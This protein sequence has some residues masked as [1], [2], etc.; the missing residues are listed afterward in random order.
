MY[1]KSLELQGFKSFAQRTRFDFPKGVTCIVGPNGSGKSN[2]VDAVR[3]VLGESS[4]KELRG[5]ESTDVI[6]NGAGRDGGKLRAALGMAEVSMTLAECREK[7]GG[8]K[9]DEVEVSRRIYRDGKGE[10]RLNG[11]ACRLRD[12]HDLI[13][14]TGI[15]RTAYSIMEQGKMDSL[16]SSKPED[17]RQVFEEAAGITKFKREKRE[18]VKEL[19]K[20]RTNLLRISDVLNDKEARLKELEVQAN[21][22]GEFHALKNDVRD[23]EVFF[24]QHQFNELV[25]KYEQIQLELSKIELTRKRQQESLEVYQKQLLQ[26][27]SGLEV[28]D[29]RRGEK[30]RL[31]Q[32]L[33]D[34]LATVKS[35][36]ALLGERVTGFKLRSDQCRQL[37]Q[38]KRAERK[39]LAERLSVLKAGLQCQIKKMAADREELLTLEGRLASKRKG[40][41]EV[42][43]VLD[44]LREAR[45]HKLSEIAVLEADLVNA[46]ERLSECV[47]KLNKRT[48]V[49]VDQQERW[50]F[51]TDNEVALERSCRE[52]DIKINSANLA[53]DKADSEIKDCVL[54]ERELRTKSRDSQRLLALAHARLDLFKQWQES[55]EDEGG[56]EILKAYPADQRDEA[57]LYG[58][59]LDLI[60]VEAGYGFAIEAALGRH[61]ELLV[62]RDNKVLVEFEQRLQGGSCGSVSMVSL[63]AENEYVSR[64]GHTKVPAGAM[65]WAKEVI[66]ASVGV[67]YLAERIF[68]DV[69]IV[70][71]VAI[72]R[73]LEKDLKGLTLVTLAGDIM[74][75]EGILRLRG[76]EVGQTARREEIIKLEGL[77]QK[78]QAEADQLESKWSDR[79]NI[80]ESRRECLA[81]LHDELHSLKLNLALVE[82]ELEAVEK[83]LEHSRARRED[84]KNE[85]EELESLKSEWIEKITQ[86]EELQLQN[87][88]QVSSHQSDE[89]ES[90]QRVAKFRKQEAEFGQKIQQLATALAVHSEKVKSA[91][92]EKRILGDRYQDVEVQLSR[93]DSEKQSAESGSEQALMQRAALEQELKSLVV[94]Y[95]GIEGELA[96]L[97]GSRSDC[98]DAVSTA[99][100]SL[101]ACRVAWLESGEKQG[102]LELEH[103]KVEVKKEAIVDSIRHA[104]D[105]DIQA[106]KIDISRHF[107]SAELTGPKERNP[108]LRS[109]LIELNEQLEGLGDVN[110]QALSDYE[111]SLEKSAFLRAQ[112]DDLVLADKEL[113]ELIKKL[114]RETR[115]RFKE[116]F[117]QV[118]LNFKEVFRSLFGDGAEADLSLVNEQDPLESGIHITAKPPGKSLR[119]IGAMS[120]GERS[121]TAVALMFSIYQIKP[122][123]FC[124][125]DELDAPLDEANIDRFVQMLERFVEGTQFIIVTH[126]TRTMERADVL[127]GVSAIEEGVSSQ[128]SVSLD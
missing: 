128:V 58:R 64:P 93:L 78:L 26:S 3:W 11:E 119:H 102:Q 125:L 15:G 20:T 69:L 16:L 74:T 59:F 95:Q 5:A 107:D 27:R 86:I 14:D 8:I 105:I 127:Y 40:R 44:D 48:R 7:L 124:F 77:V 89:V 13:E 99:E 65:A 19:E 115:K 103:T 112:Y 55:G 75:P 101:G 80:L 39:E 111:S 35:Q 1:L 41:V 25:A 110:P 90:D 76:A 91:E 79:E 9:Y 23:I 17:R 121:M 96:A 54:R 83:E 67:D 92:E 113:K 71:D 85:S 45:V 30:M 114:N 31:K 37:Y 21:R 122:S 63:A 24:A 2:V 117:D 108:Y 94:S 12:I 32:E 34:Q 87:E 82:K 56:S 50:R 97:E 47:D 49:D 62:L 43:G 18:A 84:D 70:A 120:G 98:L 106:Y 100:K 72:A 118:R 126:N 36:I 68:N 6:F 81:D 57:G 51:L 88:E 33:S 53:I 52:L 61:S 46:R 66:S 109:L 4:I 10:Y 22:A 38:E 28:M 60:E 42:E 29:N 116:T 123:P 73:K 104:F